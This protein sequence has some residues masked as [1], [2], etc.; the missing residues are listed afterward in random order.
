MSYFKGTNI[1]FIKEKIYSKT[2]LPNF[3]ENPSIKTGLP[4]VV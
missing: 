3:D 1:Y 2:G 4:F